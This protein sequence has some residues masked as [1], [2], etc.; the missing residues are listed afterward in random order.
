[1]AALPCPLTELD[2]RLKRALHRYREEA[3]SD[4]VI[5]DDITLSLSGYEVRIKGTPVVLTLKEYELLRHLMTNRGRVYTRE[6]L[7]DTI[8]GYD[9]YG[10][11]RTVDVHI[12]R[13]RSKIGDI[14]ETY[15]KTVRGIGYTF[16]AAE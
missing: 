2:F 10:G 7:L 6:Q 14:D 15:I 13:V 8:W 9:Y 5:V 11:T 4:L 3:D 16:R 12:R 1:V